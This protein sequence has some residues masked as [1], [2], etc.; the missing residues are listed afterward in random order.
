YDGIVWCPTTRNNTVI[1]RRKGKVFI[2]GNSQYPFSNLTFDLKAPEDL[3]S[4]KAIVGG[5][6][7]P[8]TYADCQKEMDMVNKAFLEVMI[9]GD[10]T[11]GVFT[12]PIP[13]Y[14]LTKEFEWDSEIA[15]L[16]FGVAAKYGL[17]YFQ[18]YVGS[19]LDPKSIRAM[20]CRLNMDTSQLINRPGGM[21]SMGDS[22]GSIG[23]VTIN[24]NRL[25]YEANTKEEFYEQLKYYMN[26]AR[27]SLE[28]KRKVITKNLKNGLMPYT[29]R[30][31]GSFHNHFSTVGL[32]GMHECCLNFL[33]KGLE[34]EEGKQFAIEILLFMKERLKVYQKETGNLYNLEATPAE[35]TSYRLAMMDKKKHPDIITSGKDTPFLTN[36]TQLPVDYTED[37]I[38]A[39]EHQKDI[40]PLYTGGTIFHTF[41]G[42][43]MNSGEACKRLVKKIAYNTKLPY[44]SITPTFS[45]C[46]THGYIMGEHRECPECGSEVDIYSRIVGYIRPIRSWNDGKKEEFKHRATF[47]E[48]SLEKDF[49]TKIEK[50]IEKK[51]VIVEV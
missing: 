20:C 4:E 23:V 37:I 35:S 12:F 44:F 38:T 27:D 42:E 9:E 48:K 41:L 40:Q 15:K 24:M 19:D 2:S 46:K 6:R 3:A 14:N 22:T 30:Y 1:V 43:K 31:L 21:W 47:S 33:K 34:T 29:R 28:I 32:V 7:M 16:L 49:K 26:L 10:A 8:Y 39:L 5:K 50:A 45:I 17:P 25:G 13:T 11:G 18:N 51:E 36:S